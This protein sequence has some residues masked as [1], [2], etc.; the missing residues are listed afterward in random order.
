M[1]LTNALIL[2]SGAIE[3][4]TLEPQFN[5][6]GTPKAIVLVGTNGSGKTNVLSIVADGLIEIAAKHYQNITP[7][8]GQGRQFFRT[9]GGR[10]QRIS[11]QFELSAMQFKDDSHEFIYRA[12]SGDVS[13]ESVSSEMDPYKALAQWSDEN[14][15]NVVGP[16][17]EIERIY[18]T[19]AYAFFPSTR[20]EAPYWA[21]LSILDRDP[22]ADFSIVFSKNLN[23]P[24]LVQNSLQALKPWIMNIM[25]DTIVN[26]AELLALNNMELI[27]GKINANSTYMNTYN[28]LTH[29]IRSILRR[30]DASVHWLNR[31]YGDRR[32][33]AFLNNQI[34][35]PSLDSFSTGQSS[36]LS[37]FGT[38]L[39]Y[40]DVGTA[41]IPLDQIRG[42]V[43]IDE[44]DAHLH[45]DLQHDALPELIK[46]FPRVQF[47][48]SSH[49]P[50]FPLGM[51]KIFGDDGYILIEL[52]SGI[53][54]DAERFSEFEASFAY[55][56]GTQAFERKV[57]DKLLESQRPLVL[58]EGETDPK[59]L[60]AAAEL[61]GFS[62]LSTGVDFDWIG[63]K[64]G[65]KE[66]TG[67]GFTNLDSALRFLKNNPQFVTRKVALLYD[68]DTKK[69]TDDIG[70]LFVRC[71]P[72]NDENTTT[73]KGVENLLPDEVFTSEF[74]L[75][76][77]RKDGANRTTV[78]ELQKTKLCDHLCSV[79]RVP[80][81]FAKFSDVL[82]ELR[83]ILIP[84]LMPVEVPPSPSSPPH[85]SGELNGTL[86]ENDATQAASEAEPE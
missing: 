78:S 56:R 63:T 76:K 37:I 1:Y 30:Q 38:V 23:K 62:D 31:S 67:G 13:P 25:M 36:L 50:L 15:K 34:A 74:Y 24:I 9:L 17:A 68:C 55:F 4:L 70:E 21:N 3:K 33:T 42:I 83:K 10:T 72:I 60:K 84:D 48:V 26:P 69:P 12:K 58:C 77:D 80:R 46:M 65:S 8:Q 5:S 39:K 64:V 47:I 79:A 85:V 51:R 75:K 16:Q 45:A 19:G 71:I 59:Y 29:I 61:I 57:H 6:D 73:D 43:L 14:E 20:F 18:R 49:S 82:M 66:G 81:H 52:P 54:I 22:E 35:M 7:P 40:G 44:A 27:R 32:I 2:N 53:R 86:I 11:A 41:A 28:G